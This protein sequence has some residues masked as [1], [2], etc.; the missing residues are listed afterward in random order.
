MRRKA[1]LPR[2]VDGSTPPPTAADAADT[3]DADASAAVRPTAV[4]SAAAAAGR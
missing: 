2:F 1:Q 4:R 3:A